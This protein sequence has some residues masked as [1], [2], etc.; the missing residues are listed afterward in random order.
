MSKEHF[1]KPK[2][3]LNA[4]NVFECGLKAFLQLMSNEILFLALL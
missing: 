2:I 1:I 3:M 4:F